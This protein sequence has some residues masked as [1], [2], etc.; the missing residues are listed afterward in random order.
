M[1][2][3]KR[4]KAGASLGL[5]LETTLVPLLP[6]MNYDCGIPKDNFERRTKK[7]FQ[8]RAD[9]VLDITTIQRNDVLADSNKYCSI[10]WSPLGCISDGG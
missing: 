6:L 4:K 10:K 5:K 7:T 8:L 1:N 9:H 2:S 3:N